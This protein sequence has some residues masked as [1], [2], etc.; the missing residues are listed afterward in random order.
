M[1]PDTPR[2]EL[3]HGLLSSRLP[4]LVRRWLCLAVGGGL[5]L[6]WLYGSWQITQLRQHTLEQSEGHLL[7]IA[8]SL[9]QHLE[10]MVNDGVSAATTAVRIADVEGTTNVTTRPELGRLLA[11]GLN[12]GDYVQAVFVYEEGRYQRVDRTKIA[13]LATAPTW[14]AS[15]DRDAQATAWAGTLIED[16]PPARFGC[17]P[18]ARKVTTHTGQS[19]WAGA[20]FDIESIQTLHERLQVRDG[21]IALVSTG[22][23]V[24]AR[25]PVAPFVTRQLSDPISA[26]LREQLRRGST[27]GIEFVGHITDVPMLFQFRVING[28]PLIAAA[29]APKHAALASWTRQL[30]ITLGLLIAATV[31]LVLLAWQLRGSLLAI[32]RRESQ[33]RLL[34]D[35]SPL[36]IVLAQRGRVTEANRAAHELFGVP[37]GQRLSGMHIMALVPDAQN[38]GGSTAELRERIHEHLRAGHRTKV[39]ALIKRLDTAESVPVEASVSSEQLDGSEGILAIVRDLTDLER[40][41]AQLEQLNASLEQRVQERTA[42][43][44]LANSD[45]LSANRELEA[46]ASSASH[47]LRAPLTTISAMAGMLREEVRSGSTAAV[48]RRVDRIQAAVH[49]MTE[50]IEGL[51]TLAGMTTQTLRWEEV[52]LSELAR[53]IAEELRHEYPALAVDFQCD[54]E[55][56]VHADP[57]LMATLLNN[58]L[59]N[60][61]KYSSFAARPRVGLRQQSS[62]VN[63]VEYVVADNGAGFDM[64]NAQRLF[65][66]FQRMHSQQ[67]FPGIGL[68]LAIAQRVVQRY[69][70]RIWAHSTPGHGAE[71]H[72]TLPVAQQ[73]KADLPMRDAG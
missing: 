3:Q 55:L 67:D 26:E 65:E 23:F 45:L 14:L 30:H 10:A 4:G 17:L 66:P 68:G 40:A 59:S 8:V 60:A 43:L 28:L 22:G 50:I 42:A 32:E 33:L 24:I 70:G 35:D 57:R 73:A 11:A 64:E 1:S 9:S 2:E 54:P 13:P 71:F 46:F 72:F 49:R 21:V 37:P 25:V 6:A 48:E 15:I 38:D 7:A 69:G 5:A 12:S 53:Q 61:W 58:L 44:Q 18:I 31:L 34:F 51:L 19:V 63:D 36:G 52:D 16:C 62:A 41:N 29:G 56:L 20:I 47:D 27:G 39:Q